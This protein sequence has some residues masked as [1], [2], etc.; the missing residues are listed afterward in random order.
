MQAG[1]RVQHA[2]DLSS[3]PGHAPMTALLWVGTELEHIWPEEHEYLTC[4]SCEQKTK[5][6][7]FHGLTARKQVTTRP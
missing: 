3:G 7:R 1:Q 4:H 5:P 6:E 2:S